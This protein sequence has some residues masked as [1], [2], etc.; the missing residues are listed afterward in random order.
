MSICIIVGHGKSKSDGY[1]SDAVNG[2]RH[3]TGAS[4]QNIALLTLMKQGKLIKP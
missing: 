2:I 3:Y 4:K 1:D